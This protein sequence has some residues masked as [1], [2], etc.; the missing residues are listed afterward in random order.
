MRRLVEIK[1]KPGRNGLVP[2]LNAL[3]LRKSNRKH[4]FQ[5]QIQMF[6]FG[7]KFCD[8]VQFDEKGGDLMNE[9]RLWIVEVP[10]DAEWMEGY[11]GSP[12]ML[13]HLKDVW[14]EHIEPWIV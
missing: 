14:K 3:E 12:G 13:N 6:V 11:D 8:Y 5:I 7:V 4:Y 1:C 9:P 2:Y 10:Y